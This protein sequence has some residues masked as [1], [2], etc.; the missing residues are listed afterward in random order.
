MDIKKLPLNTNIARL[1]SI[2][3]GNS[4]IVT[5][6]CGQVTMV[7]SRSNCERNFGNI[8][9]QVHR[10]IDE[11]YPERSEHIFIVLQDESGTFQ[12]TLKIWKSV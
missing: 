11:C 4:G 10:L 1:L 12:S 3:F 8:L 6:P 2:E 7:M 5:C 9:L